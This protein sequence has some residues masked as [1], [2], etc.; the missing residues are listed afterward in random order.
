V[1]RPFFFGFLRAPL[2]PPT[3][4][5]CYFPP[6]HNFYFI[7]RFL[8]AL[9]FRGAA[10]LSLL[11]A[12]FE[13]CSDYVP[14]ISPLT[15]RFV[16]DPSNAESGRPTGLPISSPANILISAIFGFPPQALSPPK[17]LSPPFISPG[18]R[19]PLC[20]PPFSPRLHSPFYIFFGR[21]F[22]PI[23]SFPVR[24]V[25]CL[26]FFPQGRAATE[27]CPRHGRSPSPI[28]II[29]LTALAMV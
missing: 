15:N 22:A 27:S 4:P 18:C 29:F 28:S 11:A 14:T 13:H 17:S 20:Q 10:F 21:V 6:S 5:L 23:L 1:R 25:P 3:A 24:A 9:L 16:Q 12:N 7:R 2:P 19:R 26:L 8:P